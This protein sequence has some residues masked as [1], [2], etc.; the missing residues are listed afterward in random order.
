MIYVMSDIHGRK[1]LFDKMIDK[2]NLNQNDTLFIL[3]DMVDRGGDLS[4]LFEVAELQEKGVCIPIM[5]NHEQ[6]LLEILKLYTPA[7]EFAKY[8][9]EEKRNKMTPTLFNRNDYSLGN[10]FKFPA[11][12]FRKIGSAYNTGKLIS[13]VVNMQRYCN[14]ITMQCNGMT[15]NNINEMTFEQIEYLKKYIL[16]MPFGVKCTVNGKKY[17]LVHGGYNEIYEKT[18]AEYK[19]DIRE[20][21]FLHKVESPEPLTVIFGHTTTRDIRIIKDGELSVPCKIWH[22]NVFNDKIGID[23]GA[24]YP[25]GQLACLCLDTMEE[26]YVRNDYDTIVPISR[27]NSRFDIYKKFED[28]INTEYA[29][30]PQQQLHIFS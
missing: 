24:C 23:C 9:Q 1:D 7:E 3:G 11:E 14:I 17:M 12:L 30:N 26:F 22:D 19:L 8:I 28:E 20:D 2:I 13:T 27:I 10:I 15:A 18:S 21:F 6:N 4:V 29:R 5:G 25:Y 16:S